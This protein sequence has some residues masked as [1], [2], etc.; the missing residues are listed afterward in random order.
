M[1]NT[2]YE[3]WWKTFL[4]CKECNE[5]KEVNKD[6]RYSHKQWYLWVMWR[7]KE[8]I[9]KW[10]HSERER[11]MAREFEHRRYQSPE[12]KAYLFKHAS[13]RRKRKWYWHIHLKAQRRIRKLWLR[14]ELCPIC[15]RWWRIIAHHPDYDRRYE[16]V[17]CCQIC[18]DKIHK[19]II[20][21]YNIVNLL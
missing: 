2:S 13:E 4:K 16:V 3:L 12:R 19:G 17:F 7:C 8:C 5:F 21:E 1:A 14:P 9:L 10:R 20:T 18:H 11:K 15:G 6:N